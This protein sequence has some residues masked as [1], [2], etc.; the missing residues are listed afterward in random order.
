MTEITLKQTQDLYNQLFGGVHWG[1]KENLPIEFDL[2]LNS[3]QAFTVIY[4]YQEYLHI[5]PDHYEQCYICDE[6]YNDWCSGYHL[7][8]DTE[9]ITYYSDIPTQEMIDEATK[10][11]GYNFC[12]DE[13]E[14]V[15]WYSWLRKKDKEKSSE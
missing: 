9:A 5:I 13:C 1:K 12:S 8:E 2:G 7:S 15:F 14:M 6:L 4:F 11:A 3:Q 10:D